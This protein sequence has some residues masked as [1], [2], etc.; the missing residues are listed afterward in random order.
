MSRLSRIAT[1]LYV[2]EGFV[3]GMWGSSASGM[4]F[5]TGEKILLLKRSASVEDGGVWGIPGGAIPVTVEGEKKDAKESALDESKE[6]MGRLPSGFKV[7]GKVAFK[8]GAFVFYTFIAKVQ[9]DS[10]KPTLNWESDDYKWVDVEEL[11]RLRLH[12]GVRYVLNKGGV[13]G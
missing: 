3:G 12:P 8:K 13:F 11:E 1:K 7:V 2:D 9:N 4:L 5:T 10:F 6:E